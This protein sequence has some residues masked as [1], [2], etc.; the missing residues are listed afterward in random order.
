MHQILQDTTTTTTTTT[1]N[2]AMA[3]KLERLALR[4]AQEREEILALRQAARAPPARAPNSRLDPNSEFTVGRRAAE[5]ALRGDRARYRELKIAVDRRQHPDTEY[6][7]GVRFGLA[8]Q[9]PKSV[10]AK[11]VGDH[12]GDTTNKEVQ[13]VGSAGIALPPTRRTGAVVPDFQALLRHA[14]AQAARPRAGF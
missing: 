12:A 10:L 1:P 14:R 4:R 3:T 6:W 13:V 11:R 2:T 9:Y 7:R 5:Q 8:Y